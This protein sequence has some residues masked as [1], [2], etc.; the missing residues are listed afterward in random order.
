[1]SRL[2]NH[3]IVESETKLPTIHKCKLLL[4]MERLRV[5]EWCS[6]ETEMSDQSKQ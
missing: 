5:L 3:L 1:M 4:Q 6:D 2:I